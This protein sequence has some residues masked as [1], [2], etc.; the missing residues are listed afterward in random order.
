M[1]SRNKR[2]NLRIFIALDLSLCQQI[3]II[4]MRIPFHQYWLLAIFFLLFACKKQESQTADTPIPKEQTSVKNTSLQ[5][6]IDNIAAADIGTSINGSISGT[7]HYLKDGIEHLIIP[8]TLFFN[9]PLI[10]AIHLIKKNN[11][12]VYEAAYKDGAMGA[13]RDSELFDDNGTIVFAD[14]GLEL[15]Q[16]TWPFG[17]IM[18]AKTNGEQLSWSTISTDRSFYHSVATGDLNSDGLKDIIGLTMGTKGTWIDNLHPY[19]QKANGSF[20]AD[21]N[22]ISYN[23]W[24]GAY[25]AGAVIIGNVLGDSRPEIIR[26][27]YGINPAYPSPRYSFAIFSYSAQTG[28]YEFVKT[29]G[30]FGFA[31]R[32]LGATSM[33]LADLDKDGDLDLILAYEGDQINGLEIWTNNGNGDFVYKNQTLEYSFADLQFREFEVIDA[34]GDGWQDIILNPWAGKLFKSANRGVADVF[35]HNLIWRNNNGTFEKLN[36]VQTL[37]LSQV[38]TYFKAYS[39]NNKL[40]LIGILGNSDG[41][42]I[43]TEINPIF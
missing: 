19:I 22:L 13:G 17:H 9:N 29:P 31:T 20:E 12:W 37:P 43:I 4:K 7:T 32:N 39:V 6:K 3:L 41:T 14:H 11:E 34:D 1:T 36:K 15:K 33:K 23:N 42:L 30:I 5:L 8:P 27:D 2:N 38:P 18:M 40:K 24:L 35:L 28:K 21:R 25:G 10:P 16:G 26:A